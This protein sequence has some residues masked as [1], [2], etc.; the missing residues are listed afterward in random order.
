MPQ[1]ID[2]TTRTIDAL[3]T[4]DTA[5]VAHSILRRFHLVRLIDHQIEREQRHDV[6]KLQRP[7]RKATASKSSQTRTYTSSSTNSLADLMKEI[8]PSLNK[9]GRIRDARDTEHG[10]NYTER[11]YMLSSGRNGHM[12]QQALHSGILALILTERDCA[13][14]SFKYI[15]IS[16]NLPDY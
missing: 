2:T 14:Q 13:V 9:L 6:R 4:L 7:R 12:L 15:I 5:W 11:K 1:V 16:S 10:K 3:T 8:Y